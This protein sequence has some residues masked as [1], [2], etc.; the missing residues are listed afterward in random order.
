MNETSPAPG[1]IR[2]PARDL[3]VCGACDVAVAGGG[4]AGVA[5]ALAAARTGASVCLIEKS[6]ALGGLATVGNVSIWLPI[7]D[8][9]GR[10]VS[11]GLAEELLLL[12]VADLGRARPEAR[13]RGVPDPWRP[14]GERAARRRLRYLAEFNPASYLLA[15][16]ERVLAAGV[17]LL[18]DTRVCAASTTADGRVSHLILESKSG[19]QA[20]ACAC[21]VDATGDADLCALLG[22][23]TESLDSNVLCGW[24]YHVGHRAPLSLCQLSK[25][26]SPEAGRDDAEGPFFRGD[27]AEQ[28]T[29][30]VVGSRALLREELARLRARFPDDDIQVLNLPTTACLRMTRRLVGEVSL[31]AQHVHTW[32]DDTV[33]LFSDW[34]R[35][36]PVYAVPLRALRGVRTRNLLAA[37]RCISADRTAWDVTRAIPPCAVTGQ[38]AGTA[39]AFAARDC[40]GD[41]AALPTARLQQH[42]QRQGC[43]L[44]PALVRPAAEPGTG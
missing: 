36:G 33:G 44:D 20:L 19:R 31:G 8:G 40:A 6:F 43:L 4:I 21:V 22:E 34:R 12:S 35:A 38:A 14:G 17:R 3:A 24:F 41:L 42:L 2:E 18:Y 5:A 25:R 28:V 30:H 11:A 27:D 9:R 26:F 23:E 15:L 37:G 10:Q 16:E 13:F 39:A 29:G 7:C 1:R 32:F